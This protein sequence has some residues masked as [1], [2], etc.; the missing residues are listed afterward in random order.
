MKIQH[1]IPLL[2]IVG[3][4]TVSAQTTNKLTTTPAQK[5][6]NYT[7]IFVIENNQKKIANPT[8]AD[9]RTAMH[10]PVSDDVGGIFQ[11]M[12]DGKPETL[13]IEAN[14]KGH[15]ALDYCPNADPDGKDCVFSKQDTLTFEEALKVLLAYRN[16]SADWKKLVEWKH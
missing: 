6:L 16:G 3:C 1:I 14:G 11:I 9:I 2:L 4:C 10:T 7:L 15:F 5:T 8:E 13:Q 12:P